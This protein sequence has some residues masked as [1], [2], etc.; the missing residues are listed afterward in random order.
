MPVPIKLIVCIGTR[1]EAIKLF[2]VVNALTSDARFSVEVCATAQHRGLLDQVLRIANIKPS[3]DLDLMR[4]DQTLTSVTTGVIDRFGDMLD[5]EKPDRVI[6]QGDTTTA[7]AAS[8]A[9]FYRQIP[10]AHVEAGLRT[11]D[12]F[13]PWPE[14]A[15]RKLV[16]VLADM[17]FAPTERARQAL[18]AESVCPTRVHVTGNTVIDALL[19]IK[20]R[21]PDFAADTREIAELIPQQRSNHR[22]ILVTSHRRE[23]FAGG[24]ERIATAVARL[25]ARE[26]TFVVFP[27][28]PNPQVRSV[29]EARLADHPR[30]ALTPPL[31]YVQFIYLL[32]RCHLVLTDSGGVQE[33]APSFGKPVL[34]LRDTTERPEAVEAGTAILVGTDPD[35]IVR[36]AGRLLDDEHSYSR[37]SRAHNPFGDGRA[38][39]RIVGL[40]AAAHAPAQCQMEVA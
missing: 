27:V 33:E 14:E 26:D 9:A 36:E 34:V 39:S 7:F 5:R 4:A 2:P 8:L 6:V 15:N 16:A 22:I 12:M 24:M 29:M 31:D 28:H 23:N 19:S 35:R 3:V 13:S 10:V 37:M 11:G 30:I 20:A 18:L 40:I 21:L 1:P 32:T 25:A 17:H 38:G